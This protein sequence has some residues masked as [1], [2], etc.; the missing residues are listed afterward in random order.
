MRTVELLI[1]HCTA[2]P[3]G[4][5]VTSDLIRRWHTSPPPAGRGWKQVGYTDMIH[6]NGHVERLANNNDDGKVDSWEITNGAAGFNSKSRHIVYVG[7][8]FKKAEDTRTFA[9][10]EALKKYVL[11]FIKRVPGV[12]VA[13]HSQ[14]NS[15]K[16]CPSFSVP[17]WLR[18]IGVHQ[19]NIY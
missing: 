15:S 10:K 18:L 11:E 12:K 3:R 13:G 17:T 8:G 4:R 16:D 19:K 7:G 14:L 2:T 1:I 6:L 9:Q 5:E